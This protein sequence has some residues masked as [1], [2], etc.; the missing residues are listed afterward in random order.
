MKVYFY[1]NTIM[2]FFLNIS[3]TTTNLK[4]LFIAYI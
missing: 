2:F 1:V 4:N 3:E